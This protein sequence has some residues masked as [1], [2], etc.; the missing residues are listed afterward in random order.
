[1]KTIPEKR[2]GTTK[3]E[4]KPIKDGGRQGQGGKKE[5][6]Q[7]VE[8]TMENT[9]KVAEHVVEDESKRADFERKKHTPVRDL[10]ERRSHTS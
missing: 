6:D 1:M 8:E 10:R 7:E 9:E 5:E 4:E 2:G 3:R